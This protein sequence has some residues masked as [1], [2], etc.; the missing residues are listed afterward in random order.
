MTSKETLTLDSLAYGGEAFG[1]LSN[2]KAVFVPFALPGEKVRIQ[3][4]EEKRGFARGK[5]LEVLEA[6]PERIEPRCPHFFR[7][8]LT[9]NDDEL[10]DACGGCHYQILPYDKQLVVKAEIL[11]DQL[12]RIGKLLDPPV[13]ST[14][15]SPAPW[16]YRNHVQFHMTEKGALGFVGIKMAAGQSVIPIDECHLP[17]EPLIDLWGQLEIESIPGLDRVGLRLGADDDRMVVLES[18]DPEPIEMELD[19]PVSVV[20]HGPGGSLVLGGEDHIVFQVLERSFR[21]SAGVFFQ[22]NTSMAGEMVA[23][24]LENLDLNPQDTLVDAYCG[25]GLFSAFLAP[26]VARLIGIE[27]H[28]EACKDFVVNLDE[29]ENVELYEAPVERALSSLDINADI[30]IADPPR[31]GLGHHTL[32][33]IQTVNPRVIAYISCDPAT[34]GRDARF[35]TEIGYHLRQITPF[36]LF[37]QTYHIESISFWDRDP[38]LA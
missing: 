5:L 26:R 35:L 36:D 37:P 32:K 4:V 14:V 3:L 21:A 38:I 11:R 13:Q 23:H 15:P 25:V 27:V 8:S 31:A 18:S 6:S 7:P 22:V 9:G 20:Y 34:L 12:Q 10:M 2:G 30:L 24:L 1:R 28:P 29:F 17:A 19:L 33:G 16:N